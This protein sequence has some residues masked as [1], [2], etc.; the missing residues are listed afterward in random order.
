MNT[1]LT[2]TYHEEETIP[3]QRA[4]F[5]ELEVKQRRREI[6]SAM[7]IFKYFVN[8]RERALLFINYVL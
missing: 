2:T 5:N 6:E 1:L 8:L 3:I 4:V 7:S